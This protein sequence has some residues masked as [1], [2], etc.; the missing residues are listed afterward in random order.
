MCSC[1]PQTLRQA[2]QVVVAA[3]SLW[4]NGQMFRDS[5][6]LAQAYESLRKWQILYADE[7]AHACYHYGRLLR[8]LNDP[9]S[10]MQAFID[11]THSHTRDYHIL[12]RVYSNMG[13]ICHLASEFPLSYDMY[14]KS[15]DL[16]LKNGDTL[17]YYYGLNNM[18]LELAELGK[19]DSTLALLS[20][21]RQH[22]YN[23]PLITKTYETQAEMY[24]KIQQYDS[25]LYYANLFCVQEKN[26][27]TGLLIKAQ[28]FCLLHEQD[29]AT[30]YS[31]LVIEK[32]ASLYAIH[33][34][35]YILTNDDTTKDIDDVRKTA[36]DRSDVQKQLR[37]YQGKLSQ[38]IQLLEQDINRKTDFLWLY[39]VCVTLCIIGLCVLIVIRIKRRKHT[40]L[41]QQLNDV[42][43][44]HT[45]LTEQYE[46]THRQIREDIE[47]NC[48]LLRND[49]NLGTNM[50]WGD[51]ETMCC[52][53]DQQF[54]MFTTKLRRKNILNETEI[55]LC[56]LVLLNMSRAEISRTLPY[57]LSSVGKLKD[58][59]AKLLGT[60]GKNLHNFLLKVAIEG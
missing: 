13:S 12:G 3:D 43:E 58:H 57:A 33:N 31:N 23:K 24:M 42:K 37:I 38:A 21:I 17:L 53:I 56:I 10:A 54:Y 49:E 5:A 50:A 48:E 34:A 19:K 41:S 59:T 52:L 25:A 8:E 4:T 32:S 35:L 30:Y 40:L 11:A 15:A 6:R 14:E 27:S 16:F 28:T 36:S 1:T 2:Q 60:T 39:A 22:D 9:V 20:L 46:A 26:N 44:E 45:R 29:S 7:Y 18:A 55:R 51:F 47:R